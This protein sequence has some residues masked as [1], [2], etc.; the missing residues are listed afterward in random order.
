MDIYNMKANIFKYFH[1]AGNQKSQ[2]SLIN[3]TSVLSGKFLND[4]P[5]IHQ[6]KD[7]KFTDES[8]YKCT[9]KDNLII[10]VEEF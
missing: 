3:K 7:F 1:K 2:P 4:H 10:D 9:Y 5:Q 6:F 8:L